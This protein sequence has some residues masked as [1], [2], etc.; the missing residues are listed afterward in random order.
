MRT[1]RRALGV[2]TPH[3]T[4]ILELLKKGGDSEPKK[5]CCV[6]RAVPLWPI[7]RGGNPFIIK[8]FVGSNPRRAQ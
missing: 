2:R 6:T 5:R 1:L 3:A 4:L 8:C 7:E